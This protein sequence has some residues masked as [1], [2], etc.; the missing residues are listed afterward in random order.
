MCRRKLE[1]FNFSG[2]LEKKLLFLKQYMVSIFFH[3]RLQFKMQLFWLQPVHRCIRENQADV[4][5]CWLNLINTLVWIRNARSNESVHYR[6]EN[7]IWNMSR[8]L[9]MTNWWTPHRFYRYKSVKFNVYNILLFQVF[10]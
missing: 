3:D 8:L 4:F 6:Y 7:A 5:P 10:K 2:T 9:I 1:T